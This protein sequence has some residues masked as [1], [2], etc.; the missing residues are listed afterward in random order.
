[1]KRQKDMI[2]EDN[3]VTPRSVGV[4]YAMGKREEIAPGRMK[5]LVQSRNNAQWWM[6][7]VV[8]V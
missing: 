8:K 2:P 1:M 5:R 3:A 7:L 6:C 4:Q